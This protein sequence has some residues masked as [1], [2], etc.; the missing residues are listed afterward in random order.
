MKKRVSQWLSVFIITLS[1][2]AC[3]SNS[4][5]NATR[6]AWVDSPPAGHASAVASYA[7]FGEAKAR[8]NAVMKAI[9]S[10]AL[11]KG[12]EV[13]VNG[14]V[15]KVSVVDTSGQRESFRETATVTVEANIKGNNVPV[16]AKI[17]AYWKDTRGKRVWV[18]MAED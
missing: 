16:N 4:S 6:P 1:L 7:I 2:V 17:K 15:G 5:K 18:L 11:Q 13:D 12:S 14:S 8:E 9:S 10:I 3:V